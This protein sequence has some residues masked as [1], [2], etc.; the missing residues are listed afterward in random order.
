MSYRRSYTARIPVTLR[1][2]VSYPASSTGGIKS[3]SL[4]DNVPVYVDIDVETT[5]F[6]SSVY[7]SA[8]TVDGLT[9]S[10][11]AMNAAQCAS[12]SAN[13]REISTHLTDGFYSMI[14]TDISMKQSENFSELQSRIALLVELNKDVISAH[15]RMEADVARLRRHYGEIFKGLNEDLEKRIKELDKPAFDLGEKAKRQLLIDPA[16]SLGAATAE[17]ISDTDQMAGRI[18]VARLKKLISS[19]ISDISGS[20]KKSLSYKNKI[21]HILSTSENGKTEYVPVIYARSESETSRKFSYY[22]PRM[23][24]IESVLSYVSQYVVT[25]GDEKWSRINAEEQGNIDR[26]FTNLVE[27]H[28]QNRTNNDEYNSRVHAEILKLWN[29]NKVTMTELYKERQEQ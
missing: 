24:D 17:A 1:G 27:A 9:G 23:K 6:D 26:E 12:I 4:S 5:P 22:A 21:E 11:A 25:A 3:V 28:S 13:S 16:T 15:E 7:N 20:V 18:S 8:L 14:R 10:V 2:T 19:A 29:R